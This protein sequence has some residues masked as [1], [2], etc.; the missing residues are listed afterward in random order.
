MTHSIPNPFSPNS[1][2]RHSH[3]LH[4]APAPADTL[5][6]FAAPRDSGFKASL[7]R[8]PSAL[9]Y[10][11]KTPVKE[12]PAR[13][14]Q[15]YGEA[16]IS[17]PQPMTTRGSQVPAINTL[18]A[19]PVVDNNTKVKSKAKPRKA[20][21]DVFGWGNHSSS[22]PP[23]PPV[24]KPAPTAAP[25]VPVKDT[26]MLKKLN[27]PSVSRAPSSH[28]PALA[29]VQAGL[30]VPA[31]PVA[32]R[33]SM[34][35]DPFGRP[36]E[37]AQVVE[38]VLRH[39]TPSV[40]SATPMSLESGGGRRGSVVSGKAG[41]CKTVG[42]DVQGVLEA[43]EV[44]E[45]IEKP[46][47][48]E[49]IRETIRVSEA[50]RVS[51]PLPAHIIHSD[52]PPRSASLGKLLGSSIQ[53]NHLPEL[54]E[55]PAETSDEPAPGP[56]V[57]VEGPKKTL[58]K[59]KTKSKVW[60][61]LGRSKSK[62]SKIQVETEEVP[63]VPVVKE[64]WARPTVMAQGSASLSTQIDEKYAAATARSNYSSG[65]TTRPR[66]PVLHLTAPSVDD[67]SALAQHSASTL[68][69]ASTPTLVDSAQTASTGGVWESVVGSTSDR[70]SGNGPRSAIEALMGPAR[71]PKR[72][73][74]TGLFGLSNKRS[75]DKVKPAQ[76]QASGS[77]KEKTHG[78][79]LGGF[80]RMP[81]S[82]PRITCEP[83]L[84]SLAE[85]IEEASEPATT[86]AAAAA[87]GSGMVKVVDGDVF[88][89]RFGFAPFGA[90]PE[91]EVAVKRDAGLRRVASATDKLLNL[92]TDFSFSPASSNSPTLRLMSSTNSLRQGFNGSPTPIRKVRSAMLGNK[93]SGSS[94]RPPG[95]AG[96][97][98]LKMAL[99]R[100]QALQKGEG[101][102]EMLGEKGTGKRKGKAVEVESPPRQSMVR[103]GMRNIFAPP[104]PVVPKP[105]KPAVSASPTVSAAKV[106]D[107]LVGMGQTMGPTV[108]RERTLSNVKGSQASD[109]PPDLKAMIVNA[110]G[111]KSTNA[112][113]PNKRAT[114][115]LPAPPPKDRISPRRP[116]PAPPALSLPPVP[117]VGSAHMSTSPQMFLAND[118]AEYDARD[119]LFSDRLTSGTG[120]G[121]LGGELRS[122]F[123]NS[124]DFTSEYAAL[125]QGT[126]RASFVEALRK[127]GSVGMFGVGVGLGG[128]VAEGSS[129]TEHVPSFHISKPSDS[130]TL[131]DDKDALSDDDE[132][133]EDDGDDEAFE[134]AVVHHVVGI[135]KTS[136][137]RR[138]PFKGQV[139]FQQH[140]TMRQQPSHASFGAPEPVHRAQLELPPLPALPPPSA[141]GAVSQRG[142][143]RGESSVATMSSIG[144]VIGTGEEREYTNYFD[145]TTAQHGRSHS[146][147]HSHS[148]SHS[149]S[150]ARHQSVGEPI[151]E[152]LD[153]HSPRR[154]PSHDSMASF[155][156]GASLAGRPTTRRGHHRRNSSIASVD[157]VGGADLAALIGSGPPV[158]MHNNRRSSYISKHRRNTSSQSSF[159]RPDW[160]A[161][162]RNSSSA[163]TASNFSIS[164]IVR[165]GLGDRMFQ[166]D[167]G[168]KLTSITGSPPDESKNNGGGEAGAVAAHNRTVSWDSLFDATRSKVVDDSLFDD[169]VGRSLGVNDSLFACASGSS[170]GAE[171]SCEPSRASTDADSLFGPENQSGKKNFFLRG[172]RPISTIST[173]TSASVADDTFANINVN[174][175]VARR[176][177]EYERCLQAEGEDM[178]SMTPLGKKTMQTVAGRQMLGSSM[179][180]PAKP[181]RRRPAQL[182][183]AEPPLGTPGLTSPSASETSSRLSLDTNAAS[184]TLGT[185]T[186]PRGAGHNRGKSSA[187][188]NI[189][190]TIHEMPSMATLRPKK[191]SNSP[192]PVS[193]ASHTTAREPTIVGVD[194][195]ETDEEVDRMHSVRNWVQWEREAM[196]EFRKTRNGWVDSEESKMA[197]SDWKVPTTS[198]EIAAFL[199]QSSQAYK[200]LDQLP[201][202]RTAHRRK[203]SLSDARALCSPYGLPLPKPAPINKPKMSLTT[204]YEKKM[205]TGSKASSTPSAF[206]FAFFPDDVPEA[207]CEP[208]LPTPAPAS[209]VFARF[210]RETPAS[211]PPTLAPFKPV[212]PFQFPVLDAFGLRKQLEEDKVKKLGK[213]AVLSEDKENG[214][215]RTKRARVDS[216]ARRQ[217][218]GWGRRRDSDGPEKTVGMGTADKPASTFKQ[219]T[220][221]PA[222]PLQLKSTAGQVQIK[223]ALGGGVAAKAKGKMSVFMDETFSRST[224]SKGQENVMGTSQL[225]PRAR[226]NKSPV[227]RRAGP[228]QVASQPLGL[229]A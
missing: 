103:K 136:P 213:A 66:P 82:P 202:G 76:A 207:P 217:A 70:P 156:F 225:Q 44:R 168:V 187:Q 133:Y 52:L 107:E 199:A 105:G 148:R 193:V 77:P 172:L 200:P 159:G 104:S 43:R 155:K 13:R 143:R 114:L 222:V 63:P 102:V 15:G 179:S 12:K 14:V 221:V 98:P 61:L 45:S 228:R 205:S 212:S 132:D 71:L 16:S 129:P 31:E 127:V 220:A 223:G 109:V 216:K 54:P 192:R 144:S 59:E 195:L 35:D 142:H 78:H 152:V 181:N 201:M 94:L 92:V 87:S 146:R 178:S 97:S 99:H 124:F 130:K 117:D 197:L 34:S 48:V 128:E 68:S 91:Q 5:H 210:A 208:H 29:P 123:R 177:E 53:Q 138:E 149:R 1:H 22:R 150:H 20:L 131:S 108:L 75:M 110:D 224:A 106:T 72:K 170:S 165:P 62:K 219:Q 47:A 190:S 137:V 125:D 85:E 203:S 17:H 3:Y 27:R 24:A 191:S 79:G 8:I 111:A 18:V 41:S 121:E 57:V 211:P 39:G 2:V 186:R 58:K 160:A 126:Q 4:P 182:N 115:G 49:T 185:R 161:H 67:P 218:L 176:V 141:P 196:D 42:S 147:G 118:L 84:R 7:R 90:E 80:F 194:G 60:G 206:H 209:A 198:D 157:S 32:S 33:A 88:A 189:D 145:Y 9:F 135:A 173:E 89:S 37:G 46:Q 73:S 227:K 100:K 183:F 6:H 120:T 139:A 151:E 229:R 81:G 25:A 140:M 23:P 56:K 86:V 55:V 38:Q 215:G 164:Q 83:I 174:A 112:P 65:S 40:R 153:E 226:A 64:S 113:S 95:S 74:L 175:H 30:R 69:K 171:S 19:A 158:S 119:S 188:V 169:V 122:E 134:D 180:R 167:G 163:S 116:G 10:K 50:R 36:E 28:A 166:L 101:E 21:A 11:E 96:V 93:A 184:F 214:S 204:K 154:S 162:R 26:A 51:A